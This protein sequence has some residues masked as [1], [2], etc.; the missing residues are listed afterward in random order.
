MRDRTQIFMILM[1]G[2]D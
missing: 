2:R 1:I